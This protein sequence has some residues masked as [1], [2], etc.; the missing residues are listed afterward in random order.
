M[1]RVGP[2]SPEPLGLTLVRGGANV[3][4]FSTHARRS[5]LCLFDSS[6][7]ERERIALPE[8]TGDV[9]HGFVAD[10]AGG[11]RYGLRAHGPHAPREGHRFNPAKLLVDPY[12]HALDRS[13]ALHPAMFG[14]ADGDL[15]DPVDSAPFIPKAI[16][17]PAMVPGSAARPRVPWGETVLYE[18]HVR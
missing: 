9:F 4:V 6:G 12:A 1:R 13:F 7:A 18:L 2:G 10:V 8:R 11:Q 14:A 5:G 16:A 17:V 15:A 3:A